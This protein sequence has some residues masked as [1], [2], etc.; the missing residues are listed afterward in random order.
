MRVTR[1]AVEVLSSHLWPGNV[2]ELENAIE[3]ACA[4][5]ETDVIRLTDLP[6]SLSQ[7]A[8]GGPSDTI[9]ITREDTSPASLRLTPGT[10]EGSGAVTATPGTVTD[11]GFAAGRP[12]VPLKVFLRD[13]EQ[14]YLNR[15]LAQ[16]AGDKEEAARL[17]GVSLAT[18]YRKLAG[19]GEA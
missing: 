7:H 11:T 12:V 2:R 1:Q 18:L 4:L 17:L 5:A 14:Q 19:E 3:R 16:T 8:T 10:P 9:F 6:P 13:Q 15:A